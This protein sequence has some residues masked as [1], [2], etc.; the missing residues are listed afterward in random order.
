MRCW[1]VVSSLVLCWN[2]GAGY[3]RGIEEQQI[4]SGGEKI[5]RFG[6]DT[7]SNWWILT[8]PYERYMRLYVNGFRTPEAEYILPPV[9]S[10]D[11][12][13][14]GTV[15]YMQD[16]VSLW[17]DGQ[18]L[19]LNY[20]AAYDMQ[21][22]DD[23]RTTSVIGYVGGQKELVRFQFQNGRWVQ[24]AV[25][26]LP[27]AFKGSL[28]Q[29]R[30][31]TKF[32]YVVAE[33]SQVSLVAEQQQ[34]GPFDQI[35]HVHWWQ[36]S[37]PLFAART[38]KWWTVYLGENPLLTGVDTVLSMQLNRQRRIAVIVYKRYQLYYIVKLNADGT[39]QQTQ[40]WDKV[41]DCWL[42]PSATFYGA[43]VQWRNQHYFL[44]D[45]TRYPLQPR[46]T[47]LQMLYNGE[48]YYCLECRQWCDL[49]L[50]GD[51][52]RLQM[53][54]GTQLRSFVYLPQYEAFAYVN[55]PNFY[56]H[57]LQSKQTVLSYQYDQFSPIVFN[58]YTGAVE[59][60]ARRGNLLYLVRYPFMSSGEK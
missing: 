41:E 54:V 27:Q 21:F 59:V 55:G 33:G 38:G 34:L 53:Q 58:W 20:Q 13:H 24:S 22:A 10:P 19:A 30:F 36:D 3:A 44:L 35:Q 29:D 2:I 4:F 7:T 57:S 1:M 6:L 15:V 46:H 31:L 52:V 25:L 16:A 23:G 42:H 37:I 39:V 47:K 8:Q 11:G 5:L 18:P 9:F 28:V 40:G 51:R 17:L 32:L 26:P 48:G 43:L 14:W 12:L 50:N 49:L 56:V 60:L 45:G